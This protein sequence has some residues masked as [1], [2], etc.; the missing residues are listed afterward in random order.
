LMDARSYVIPEDIK[1]IAKNVLWHRL[2]LNYE[3]IANDI[4]VD[5]IVKIIMDWINV[6]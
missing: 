5:D 3:A 2:V 4:N 1:K 6:I